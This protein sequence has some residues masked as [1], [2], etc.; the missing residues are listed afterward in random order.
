MKTNTAIDVQTERGFTLLEL[1]IVIAI[2]TI[3]TGISVLGVATMLPKYR[4]NGAAA[5]VRSDLYR[6]KVL[7]VKSKVRYKIGFNANGYQLLE[8]VAETPVSSRS[9]NQEYKG[10]SVDMGA[11]ADPIFYPRGTASACTITL[12]NTRG[13]NAVIT[14]TLAGRIRS[15]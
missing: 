10:V 7:A 9:I 12:R 6:A 4:L 8:G 15:Q 5:T 13:D 2:G 14:T 1:L 11:T 3:V